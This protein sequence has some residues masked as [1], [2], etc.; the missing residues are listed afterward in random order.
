MLVFVTSPLSALAAVQIDNGLP[1]GGVPFESGSDPGAGV[2]APSSG[3]GGGYTTTLSSLTDAG[4]QVGCSD[5]SSIGGAL[6]NAFG[7]GLQQAI[8][9]LIRN[10]LG[11]LVGKISAKAGPFAP[12]INTIANIGINKLTNLAQNYIGKLFGG[13]LSGGLGSIANA[14]TGGAP[15]AVPTNE[16]GQVAPDTAAIRTQ[17]KST[18]DNIQVL[19]DKECQGD[20]VAKALANSLISMTTRMTIDFVNGGCN[21]NSCI[22]QN[23][24]QFFRQGIDIVVQDIIENQTAGLCSANRSTVQSIVLTQYQYETNFGRRIQCQNPNDAEGGNPVAESA[25]EEVFNSAWHPTDVFNDYINVYS[26]IIEQSAAQKES[27]AAHVHDSGLYTYVYKCTKGQPAPGETCTDGG[28]PITSVPPDVIRAG[29]HNAL[30]TPQ[31]QLLNADEI[32]EIIDS[33]MASLTQVAYQGVDGILGLSQKNGSQGSYLDQLVGDTGN[34][35]TGGAQDVV[36][37]DIQNAIYVEQQYHDTLSAVVQS[38]TDSKQTYTS[39]ISCLQGKANAGGTNAA[40]AFEKMNNASSTVATVINPLLTN[41]TAQTTASQNTID[42]L[43]IILTEAESALTGQDI[44]AV[45]NQ[46]TA[47]VNAGSVHTNVDLTFLQNDLQST[48]DALNV[49]VVDS[50]QLVAECQAL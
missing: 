28:V 35:A 14:V 40:I 47:L 5:G 48:T 9:G 22:I 27:I 45:N 23:L 29:L 32:G 17:T 31:D 39:A 49:L 13:A 33:L 7:V 50:T 18:Q 15:A 21:G 36:A 6:L 8:P 16:V 4:Q 38:L 11:G 44:V 46:Y 26:G 20:R 43:N 2:G 25:N 1:G 37:G 19:K 24:Q 30:K 3:G 34:A 12:I 10:K 41:L 42:Q